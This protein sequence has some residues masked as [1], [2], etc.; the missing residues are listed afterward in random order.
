MKK[1]ISIMICIMIFLMSCTSSDEKAKKMNSDSQRSVMM[2]LLFR[3]RNGYPIF[4]TPKE[5]IAKDLYSGIY[6]S[7]RFSD[8]LKQVDEAL[9][10]GADPNYCRGECG[11]WDSNPLCV[12][13]EG[14]NTTYSIGE[15]TKKIVEEPYDIYI[16]KALIGAGANIKQ[17]PYV[18]YRIYLFN[19]DMLH[20]LELLDST[21]N[22]IAYWIRDCNRILQAMIDA[23]A[24]PDMKGNPYPFSSEVMYNMNEKKA[25][26]YFIKGTRP[27]EEA[28]EKGIVWESQVDLLLLYT[29]LNEDSL[30]AAK[31]SNDPKMIEKIEKLW[32]KQRLSDDIKN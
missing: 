18:W 20:Q 11:Y 27:I 29:K 24:D 1:L 12:L 7:Y 13:I 22:E 2:E 26:T 5:K 23:G 30:E 32:Q 4:L 10:K 28:I 21:P 8:G 9:A 14:V 15:E 31:R 17:R 16:L 6:R 3:V 25:S 19:N